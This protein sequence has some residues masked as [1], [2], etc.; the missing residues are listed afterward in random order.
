MT[1]LPDFTVIETGLGGS[2]CPLNATDLDRKVDLL[3]PRN[4]YLKYTLRSHS[5]GR[6]IVDGID[7]R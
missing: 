4:P 3:D 1:E 2:A 5:I 7:D 6:I